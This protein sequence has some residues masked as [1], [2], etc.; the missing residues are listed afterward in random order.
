M[1]AKI[2]SSSRKQ[3]YPP[4]DVGA[5]TKGASDILVLRAGSLREVALG[6]HCNLETDNAIITEKELRISTGREHHFL[7]FRVVLVMVYLLEKD[8]S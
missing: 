5:W 2:R 7:N 8:H 3:L 6:R 4:V 1:D